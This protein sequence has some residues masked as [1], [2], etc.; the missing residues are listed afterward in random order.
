MA[1]G[2]GAP[3]GRRSAPPDGAR[4]R[5]DGSPAP[6]A[7]RAPGK[8]CGLQRDRRNLRMYFSIV[9]P[10][11]RGECDGA[12]PRRAPASSRMIQA[13]MGLGGAASGARAG[14]PRA[15]GAKAMASA[16]RGCAASV[17][18]TG[19]RTGAQLAAQ[20]AAQ[21]E[22]AL[23]PPQQSSACAAAGHCIARAASSVAAGTPTANAARSTQTIS[24]RS[25]EPTESRLAV[26]P[27]GVNVRASRISFMRQGPLS[28]GSSMPPPAPRYLMEIK[29]Q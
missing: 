2:R 29:P 5:S 19:T 21:P 12:R 24:T 9:V 11:S 22:S 18:A 7:H 10:R 17:G 23:A 26:R 20:C 28:G 14:R 8:R 3:A 16:A 15:R 6:M 25:R 4:L 27:W 13:R 1:I